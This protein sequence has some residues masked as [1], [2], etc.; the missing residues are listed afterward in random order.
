[1]VSRKTPARYYP[2]VTD[3][4]PTALQPVINQLFDHVYQLESLVRLNLPQY[5]ESL[6][7]ISTF[8]ASQTVYNVIPGVTASIGVGVWLVRMYL[9]V[10]IDAAS[11]LFQAYLSINNSVQLSRGGV[12]V[13]GLGALEVKWASY[14]WRVESTVDG[15][16]LKIAITKAN[17]GGAAAANVNAKLTALYIGSL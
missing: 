10:L 9:P 1:M 5:V 8:A 12:T 2:S 16:L 6:P 17:A 13:D 3:S 11:G 15:T 4:S 14:E 7:S